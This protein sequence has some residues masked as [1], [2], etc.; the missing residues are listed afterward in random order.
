MS[1][2]DI[3]ESLVNLIPECIARENTVIAIGCSLDSI[4]VACPDD[5][6]GPSEQEKMQFILNRL[7]YWR[8]FPRAEICTAIDL[9]YVPSGGVENCGWKFRYQCPHRWRHFAR[10]ESESVRF[11]P[12]CSRHVYLCTDD[13]DV[14][15]Y[16]QL[17]H[18]VA[19]MDGFGLEL[20][21]EVDGLSE[22]SA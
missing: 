1:L 13:Q 16:A 8:H 10:T 21:G 7:V 14:I 9:H 19:K 11:C 15:H 17:G 12:I 20:I 4:T 18:C 2:S 3:P 5:S 22:S 6:F